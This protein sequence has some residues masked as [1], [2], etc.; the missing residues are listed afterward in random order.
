MRTLYLLSALLLFGA[1]MARALDFDVLL[2]EFDQ[3]GIAAL[4]D[5]ASDLD[6][7]QDERDFHALTNTL[8]ANLRWWNNVDSNHYT[9]TERR[10]RQ[11]RGLPLGPTNV[12]WR[13]QSRAAGGPLVPLGAAEPQTPLWALLQV[14]T[15][16]KYRVWLR[17]QVE[18]GAVRHFKLRL[19]EQSIRLNQLKVTLEASKRQEQRHPIRFEDEAVRAS[20]PKGRAWVW[21]YHDFELPAGPLRC[22]L[23][24]EPGDLGFSHLLLTQ[25]KRFVPQLGADFSS[26]LTKVYLRIRVRES[27]SPVVTCPSAYFGYHWRYLPPG[28]FFEAWSAGMGSRHYRDSGPHVAPRNCD[29]RS[30]LQVDEWSDWLDVTWAS[31]WT[32]NWATGHLGFNHTQGGKCDVELAWHPH[33]GAVLKRIEVNIE[34]GKTM[35]CM[36]LA[37]LGRGDGIAPDPDGVTGVWG[38]YRPAFTNWFKPTSAFL[39]LYAGYAATARQRL[40]LAEQSW[41]VHPGIRFIATTKGMPSELE[42]LARVQLSLGLNEVSGLPPAIAERIGLAPSLEFAASRRICDPA[43]L[44]WE[45]LARKTVEQSLQGHLQRYPG[46]PEYATISCLGDEIGLICSPYKANQSPA[47]RARFHHYLQQVVASEGTTAADFFGVSRLEEL[48][49]PEAAPG[50][51]ASLFERRLYSHGDKFLEQLTADFYRPVTATI[52]ELVPH[53][54]TYANYTP[55]PLRQG[56]MTMNGCGWFH[57]L[58]LGGFSLAWGEDWS[59]RVGSM[60]GHEIVSFFA[61]LVECAAREHNLPAGFYNVPYCGRADTNIFSALARRI[62]LLHI[63]SFG[64]SYADTGLEGN[65]SDQPEA[66]VELMRATYAISLIDKLLVEGTQEPR[67]TALLYNRDQERMYNGVWGEQAERTSTFAALTTAHRNADIILNEDLTPDHLA[68]YNVLHLNGFCLPRRAVPVL[69]EWVA[70]GNL[71]VLDAHCASQD[72]YRAP[73]PEMERLRGA[74]SELASEPSGPFQPQY[75]ADRLA[76]V[77]QVTLLESELTPALPPG[78]IYAVRAPLTPQGGEVVAHFEDGSCAGVL[79]RVGQGYV[80]SWGFQPGLFYKGEAAGLSNFVDERLALFA[81]P[82]EQL[83]GVP[84]LSISAPQV[85]LT[86]FDHDGATGIMLNNFRRDEWQPGSPPAQLRLKLGRQA[87]AVSSAFHG[88]LEFENEADGWVVIQTPLPETIDTLLIR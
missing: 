6:Q 86:R 51:R 17:H 3:P 14:P 79:H 18:P 80:L 31:I 21:E 9:P 20:F 88:E 83:H 43:D 30:E 5:L 47:C 26:N 46:K 60:T 11:E 27:D 15:A 56:S 62:R 33:P 39:D 76:P 71:L 49:L 22:E 72:E 55:A 10:Q 34:E 59:Y 75:M 77:G 29:G 84:P 81:K 8:F 66:Y 63:F 7:E 73:L 44:A 23:L 36:P 70:A 12:A 48:R 64:P 82:I 24:P 35:F 19:G 1:G 37:A 42:G 16:G 2:D 65:W 38:F 28:A 67:R 54:L 52:Q 32:G 87:A 45:A 68:A 58:R 25:S 50:R 13:Y 40:G 53:I 57:N 74:R 4:D 85:E 69:E 41:Q 61:A 78:N